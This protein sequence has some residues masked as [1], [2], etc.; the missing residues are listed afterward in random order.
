M[1]GYYSPLLIL[2]AICLYHAYRH[3]V[4][5]RWYWLILF[6]PMVGCLLYLYEAFY[7]RNTVDTFTQG[8]K[9]LINGNH[10]IEHLEKAVR[11]AN[12]VTNKTNLADAYAEIGR[13]EEAATLYKECLQGFMAGDP[14]LRMKV[15]QM[16]FLKKDYTAAIAYGDELQQEKEKSFQQ[17]QAKVVYAWALY[18][19]GNPERAEAVF[20]SMDSI[21]TNYYHRLEYCKFLKEINNTQKLAVTLE[22]LLQEFDYMKGPERKV[23]RKIMAQVKELYRIHSIKDPIESKR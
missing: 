15:L 18:Y 21:H 22:T 17:S 20:T 5:Q 12:N 2:Q 16:N 10:H 4:E 7:N 23:H 13:Y 3:N 1:L 6:I 19:G 8:C 14:Y 11:F 9:Q